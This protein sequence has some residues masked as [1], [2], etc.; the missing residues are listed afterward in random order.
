ML[1]GQSQNTV[2]LELCFCRMLAGLAR[3]LRWWR[4]SLGAALG[5]ILGHM[6]PSVRMGPSVWTQLSSGKKRAIDKDMLG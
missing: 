1:A 3:N 2:T 4:Q 6:H 5:A